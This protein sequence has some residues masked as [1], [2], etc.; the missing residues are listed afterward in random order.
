VTP[1]NLLLF[2]GEGWCGPPMARSRLLSGATRALFAR[3]ASSEPH[4]RI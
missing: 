1:T 4:S 3:L 2:T